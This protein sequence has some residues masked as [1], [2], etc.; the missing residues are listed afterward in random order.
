MSLLQYIKHRKQII[1]QSTHR[2]PYKALKAVSKSIKKK[3]VVE[4]GFDTA[5]KVCVSFRGVISIF[6][7][8]NINMIILYLKIAITIWWRIFRLQIMQPI[9]QFFFLRTNIRPV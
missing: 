6:F 1:K 4:R 9:Y 7:Y 5:S 8:V 2:K 3:N